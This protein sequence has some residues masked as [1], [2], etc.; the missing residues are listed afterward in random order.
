MTGTAWFELSGTELEVVWH[1][2]ELGRV[3]YPLALPAVGG[4]ARDRT[5]LAGQ[6]REALRRR[7]LWHDAPAAALARPLRVLAAGGTAVDAVGFLG[8]PL[9]G[10]LRALAAEDGWDGAVAVL[11]RDV[12]RVAAIPTGAFAG[13]IVDIVGDVPAGPGSALSVPVDELRSGGRRAAELTGRLA[14]RIAGGQFG[15]TATG[16]FGRRRRA[17]TLVSWFD[18]PR[19]RYLLVREGGWVSFAPA[20]RKRVVHRVGEV[21]TEVVAGAALAG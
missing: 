6:V 15:A 7:E 19:G 2:L 1:E 14:E 10:P 20:D 18:T 9:G 3:P 11:R 8:G 5:V 16:S 12:V 21:V 17:R 13:A 4:T